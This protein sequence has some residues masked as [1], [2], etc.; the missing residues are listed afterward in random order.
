MSGADLM[1]ESQAEQ[2]AHSAT[3]VQT[4]IENQNKNQAS[5]KTEAKTEAE[6]LEATKAEV[7]ARWGFLK[8]IVNIDSFFSSGA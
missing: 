3:N 4:L 8:N 1:I 6:S 2:K 7:M 5:Q